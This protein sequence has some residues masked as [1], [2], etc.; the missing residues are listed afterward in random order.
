MRALQRALKQPEGGQARLIQSLERDDDPDGVV[1]R[2]V[3][4]RLTELEQKRTS[5]MEQLQKLE[6]ERFAR[7]AGNPALL[8][9]LPVGEV[10]L[11]DGPD[12]LVRICWRPCAWRSATTS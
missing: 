5:K 3:R 7:R 10:N 12:E 8:D 6:A 9:A 11:L 1:F 2:R 4:D